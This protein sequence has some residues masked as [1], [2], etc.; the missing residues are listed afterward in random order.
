MAN[1][2]SKLTS[3]MFWSFSQSIGSQLIGIIISTILAR[4]MMP[5]AYG[6]I[7]AAHIFTGIATTFVSGSF[8]NVIIQKKDADAKDCDTIFWW[9]IIFSSILYVVLFFSAPIIVNVFNQSFD[10]EL[11][12]KVIRVLGIGVVL[13]SFNSFYRAFLQKKLQFK[14]IFLLTL[15]GTLVSAVIGIAMAYKGLGVWALVAQNVLSYAINSILFLIF[16][17]WV[18]HFYFSFIRF[19]NMFSYGAKMLLSGVLITVQKDLTQIA[20]GNR[21]T[22]DSLAYYNKGINYP[23][24]FALNIVTSINAALFPVM[25]QISDQQKLKDLVRKFNR[26]S[27]FVMT[28]MMFG[29]AAVGPSFIELLLTDRWSFAIPFLQICCF[30]YA[31]QPLGMSSLQYLRATGRATEYLVLDIIRKAISV[32]LLFCAFALDEG[33]IYMALAELLSNFIAILVNFYPGKKHLDYKIR[34]QIADV[35]PKFLLSGVMFAFVYCLGWINL[36]LFFKFILQVFSGIVIYVGCAKVFRM[37]E[38][39]E[40]ILIIRNLLSKKKSQSSNSKDES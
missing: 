34:E 18:P 35:L 5:E 33:V 12:V 22:A 32:I 10:R 11:L 9:N 15:S 38:F 39:C 4:L 25:S 13:A 8:A 37:Q 19:K 2:G 3:S 27:A 7:A 40:L 16:S 36:P 28:P 31:I 26:I 29:F 21:Y 14:K 30:T 17:H 23:K 24:L 6:I 20:I 1:S